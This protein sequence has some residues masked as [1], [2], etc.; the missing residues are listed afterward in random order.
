MLCGSSLPFADSLLHL[1][2]TLR[3]DLNDS[4]D[5]IGKTH[6]M[7]RKANCRLNT[8]SAT[9][10]LTKPKLF[11]SYFLSLYGSALWNL[12]CREI[13][14]LEVAFNRVLRRISWS[15]LAH[16]HTAIVNCTAKMQN[17]F[18]I[19]MKCSTSLLSAAKASS[20]L[21]VRHIFSDSSALSYTP[22]CFNVLYGHRY[23]KV[24]SSNDFSAAC[25]IRSICLSSSSVSEQLIVSLSCN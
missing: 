19:I 3:Y 17:F 13:R 22:T 1:G 7:I 24:Y 9:D 5:I 25:V 2:H 21:I 15:L 23:H 14:T 20:S 18:N 10:V 6:D 16:S 4:D 12:S 8:L 11:Q